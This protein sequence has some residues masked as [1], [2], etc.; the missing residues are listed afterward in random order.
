M[1][2]LVFEDWYKNHQERILSDF[3]TFLRFPSIS[4]NKKH[5]QDIRKTASWL[6]EYMKGIGLEVDVWETSHFP[7]VFGSYLKAGPNRPTLLIYHH[8][9][10]QPTDPLDLW[11]NDPFEPV[12][13][14]N[15]VY[16]RGAS[17]N[18]G[19]CFYSLTAL[20]AYLE[21]S[22]RIELNI[23]IVI[24][25]EEESSSKGIKGILK[26]KAQELKADYLIVVDAGISHIES[27]AITL[28]IRGILSLEIECKNSF[29]DLHS[30]VHGGIA[31]N[32]NRALAAIIANMWESSGRVAIPHFYDDVEPVKKWK[33]SLDMTFDQDLYTKEFGVHAF[34]HEEGYSLRESNWLRPSLEVNGM[35]GG[36]I[37]PGF[38]TVIPSKAHAKIS[39]RL[40]PNQNPQKIAQN[41]VEYFKKNAPPGIEISA[42]IGE[43]Y[44]AFCCFPDS[45]IAKTAVLAYEEIFKKPCKYTACGATVPIVTELAAVSAAE[46]ILMGVGLPTNNIHAPNEHFSM[47]C[48]K[49]GFLVMTNLLTRLSQRV[50][51]REEDLCGNSAEQERRI[52]KP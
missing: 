13:K 10:V 12:I 43:G 16:A 31:L 7:V 24:E 23:K 17:D 3:F 4:T 51:Q 19:Q 52:E 22:D 21:L 6:S 26:T 15:C 32:P 38:K 29:V 14:E 28:G 37:E 1:Q 44:K 35:W 42:E 20:K 2:T 34:S 8:Y 41:I 11:E 5:E 39:C 47:D 48:F 25:G 18:K 27:P 50:E 46:T 33:D 49:L 36:Y 40:V 9:D 45:V 30:G